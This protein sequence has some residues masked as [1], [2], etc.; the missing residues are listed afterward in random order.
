M[1]DLVLLIVFLASGIGWL[2]FIIE[3]EGDNICRLLEKI[4]KELGRR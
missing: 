2:E 4:L 3:R 1:D